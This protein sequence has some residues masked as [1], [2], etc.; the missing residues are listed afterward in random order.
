M[1]QQMLVGQVIHNPA[2]NQTQNHELKPTLRREHIDLIPQFSGS[3]QTLHEFLEVTKKLNERFYNREDPDDFQNYMLISAIKSKILPPASEQIFSSSI[4][5]YEQIAEALLNAYA[6]RRDDLTLVIELVGLRQLDETPFKFHDRIQKTL[7]L[8]IAYL[9]NHKK[10]NADI[11]IANY[12]RLALR[13]FLLNL[14]EPLG[15]NLRTRQPPDLGTA[16]SW[17]TND[18]QTLM[19]NSKYKNQQ[20]YNTKPPQSN[21]QT[22]KTQNTGWQQNYKSNNNPQFKPQYNKPQNQPQNKNPQGGYKPQYQQQQGK[23]PAQNYRPNN[24]PPPRP[25]STQAVPM[26]WRTT[27]PNF[28]NIYDNQENPETPEDEGEPIE[29]NFEDDTEEPE[30]NEQHFLEDASLQN[31][32]DSNY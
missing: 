17:L 14:K 18:Y 2:Q 15:S 1:I 32:Q 10:E 21:V 7:N 6:D 26:S 29:N 28:H 8:I 4:N 13:C 19:A 20:N 5:T 22:P 27:N 12:K 30:G 23:P 11:L 3:P 9:Q 24:Q 16:L 31:P 25:A